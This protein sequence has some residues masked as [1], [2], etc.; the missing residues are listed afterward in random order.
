MSSSCPKG[1]SQGP[2]DIVF[3]KKTL[4]KSSKVEEVRIKMGY[5]KSFVVKRDERG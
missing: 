2:S 5:D 3:L 4:V 1:P